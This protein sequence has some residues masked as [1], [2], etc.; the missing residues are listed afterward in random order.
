MAQPPPL[1]ALSFHLVTSPRLVTVHLAS[2]RPVLL[3]P[4]FNVHTESIHFLTT[5]Q[6]DRQGIPPVSC[7][8]RVASRHTNWTPKLY[9]KVGRFVEVRGRKRI[10][11]SAI[12]S[13]PKI[14][15][16]RDFR[17]YDKQ[18]RG[19]VVFNE[20]P[21]EERSKRE[22]EKKRESVCVFPI[23]IPRTCSHNSFKSLRVIL[24]LRWSVGK[25]SCSSVYYRF[26]RET[27]I[28]CCTESSILR[29]RL[30]PQSRL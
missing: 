22:K 16:G 23:R 7:R 10:G 13:P 28:T 17:H 12:P 5:R 6:A 9:R 2:P 30:H 3:S 4:S 29:T 15:C 18:V 11:S 25:G 21:R 14:R 27:R 19:P 24:R 26:S 1:L 20:I 8:R